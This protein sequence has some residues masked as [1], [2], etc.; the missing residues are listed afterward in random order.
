MAWHPFRNIGLKIVALAIGTGLWFVVSG[1]RVDRVVSAVPVTYR[2]TPATLDLSNQ[3]QTVDVHVRGVSRQ[4][5]SLQ[6]GDLVVAVD[7]SGRQ[8]GLVELPLRVDQ[9]TAPAGMEVVQVDPSVVSLLLEGRDTAER[10]IPAV[11][12]TVRNRP[13]SARQVELDPETVAVT[14]RG[15]T[16]ALARLDPATVVAEL[17][18]A[19]L[20]PGKHMLPVRATAAGTLT[21]TVIRPAAVSVQIR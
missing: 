11:A 3:T 2:N 14:V 6:P 20:G 10:T 1:P 18:L 4:V 7:L 12:I 17:D 8:A 5:T 13:P 9:I 15:S 16:A 21:T 19:G